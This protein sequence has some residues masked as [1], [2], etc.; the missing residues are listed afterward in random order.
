M[1][2]R[3][4]NNRRQTY[5]F[6]LVDLLKKKILALTFKHF[7]KKDFIFDLHILL[8]KYFKMARKSVP[9]WKCL[10]FRLVMLSRVSEEGW[11]SG[12]VFGLRGLS[13]G[14]DP[15]ITSCLEVTVW[16]TYCVPRNVRPISFCPFWQTVNGWIQRS[17]Q[18]M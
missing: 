8:M 1:L 15:A 16:L 6:S 3:F 12:L 7:K 11:C 17:I 4:K 10:L 2:V 13:P 5:S 14:L 9:F 18:F